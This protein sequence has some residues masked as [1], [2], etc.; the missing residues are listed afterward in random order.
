VL[1]CT[2]VCKSRDLKTGKDASLS[3]ACAAASAGQRNGPIVD[4]SGESWGW[5]DPP[6]LTKAERGQCAV[7][8]VRCSMQAE[9]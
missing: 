3:P 2:L 7:G 9:V 1:L 5:H 8:Q 6:W 4:E